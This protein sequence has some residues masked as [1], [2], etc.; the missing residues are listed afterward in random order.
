MKEERSKWTLTN[1]DKVYQLK[2]ESV[3][4]VDN[5]WLTREEI[6]DLRDLL[7]TFEK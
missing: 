1:R 5:I 4:G 3:E 2:L 7:N 6:E